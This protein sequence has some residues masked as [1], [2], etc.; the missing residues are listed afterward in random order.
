MAMKKIRRRRCSVAEARQGLA[1]IEV[2]RRDV[3]AAVLL[4][5][6][7]YARLPQRLSV[8]QTVQAFRRS[9]DLEALGGDDALLE[10]LRDSAPGRPVQ[11]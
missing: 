9:T 10:R 1:A 11:L 2:T 3:P 4:S 5:T 6:E 8:W 7:H